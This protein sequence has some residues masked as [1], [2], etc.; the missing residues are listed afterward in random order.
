[1]VGPA[2]L[3]DLQRAIHGSGPGPL[4]LLLGLRL[5]SWSSTDRLPSPELIWLQ[6][7]PILETRRISQPPM[8][9]R[10]LPDLKWQEGINRQVLGQVPDGLPAGEDYVCKTC[11]AWPG[12]DSLARALG[13]AG[14]FL[15]GDDGMI[16][17]TITGLISG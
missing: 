11:S 16:C 7:R 8:A 17:K 13:Q 10:Q 6:A 1:V 15:T 4:V 12:R 9:L 2:D 5:K 14:P 3:T